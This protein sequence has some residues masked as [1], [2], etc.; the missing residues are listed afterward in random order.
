MNRDIQR[1]GVDRQAAP[2]AENGPLELRRTISA[3]NAMQA[4]IQAFI[5]A[6][7][8]LLA[9]ISHDLRTPLTRMRLRSELTQ[10]STLGGG[11]SKDIDEMSAM[12]NSALSVFREDYA[13]DEVPTLIDVGA[14]VQVIIDQ[15]DDKAITIPFK[16][17]GVALAYGRPHALSRAVLN[18]IDNAVRHAGEVEAE[19]SQ[20]HGN[21]VIDILDRGP[22]L[23]QEALEQVFRPF[24][25]F[26]AQAGRPTDGFGLGLV[27]ARSIALAHNGDV[28]ALNRNGGGL[29]VSLRLPAAEG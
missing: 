26:D 16:R 8:L 29:H 13:D 5:E 24:F 25:R 28:Q 19:L 21:L 9:T 4:R 18:I 1:L 2:V 14:L 7:T 23:P 17:A 11:L 10:D 12:V 20:I 27:S 3:V 22:G 6:R 15:Y